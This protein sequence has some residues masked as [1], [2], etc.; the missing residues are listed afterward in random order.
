MPCH[1]DEAKPQTVGAMATFSIALSDGNSPH[2]GQRPSRAG[3]Y[4]Y[5]RKIE[6]SNYIDD[7]FF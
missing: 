6:T 4:H 1:G 2:T 7:H 3:V 5:L